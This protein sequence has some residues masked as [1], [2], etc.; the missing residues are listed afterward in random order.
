M[1]LES[2]RRHQFNEALDT[3]A[4]AWGVVLMC[5]WGLGGDDVGEHT[6]K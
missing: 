2:W 3:G 5:V 4:G 1:Q 6:G